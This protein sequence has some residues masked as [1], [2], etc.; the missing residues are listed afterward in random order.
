MEIERQSDV[1]M[2]YREFKDLKLSQLGFGAMRLGVKVILSGMSNEEQ[3]HANV[4]T[5]EADLPLN[6]DEMKALMQVA[7]IP[8]DKQPAA[9]LHCGSCEQVCPQQ[10]HISDVM[11]DF[12]K[13]LGE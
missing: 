10:I 2:Q 3:L 4:A 1:D 8:Q 5:F 12:V 7:A 6:D 9:C 13:V 11:E